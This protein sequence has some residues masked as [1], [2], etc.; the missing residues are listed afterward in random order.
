MKC[1]TDL[2]ATGIGMGI[3]QDGPTFIYSDSEGAVKLIYNP[4]I[5]KRSRHIKIPYMYVRQG[6]ASKKFV[7][8]LIGSD[9]N[10]A[11]MGTKPLYFAAH[12][13]CRDAC[14][15]VIPYETSDHFNSVKS[16]T[17]R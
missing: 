10:N 8:V 13:N 15:Y 14:G 1:I 4:C 6:I 3:S 7:L 16:Q 12:K 9:F 2:T 11:D 5:A 17:S